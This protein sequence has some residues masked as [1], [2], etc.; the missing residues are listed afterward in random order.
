MKRIDLS[1]DEFFKAQ[2][3]ALIESAPQRRPFTTPDVLKAVTLQ[4]KLKEANGSLL[5][6]DADYAFVRS[7]VDA[8]DWR[9]ALPQ[10]GEFLKRV[11]E[12]P[13]VKVEEAKPE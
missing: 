4:Q 2:F 11:I 13:D 3:A 12:A 9:I 8:Q 7:I 10:L 1:G 5:L 6:E